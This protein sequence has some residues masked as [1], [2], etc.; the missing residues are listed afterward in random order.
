MISKMFSLVNLFFGMALGSFLNVVAKRTIEGRRWWGRERSACD[1]CGRTLSI[2]DLIPVFSYVFLRGKCRTCKAPIGISCFLVEVIMGLSLWAVALVY[3]PTLSFL[4]SLVLFSC[5]FL[6]SLTD[7]YSGY[8]YDRLV[9][10]FLVTG[11]ALR[12]LGGLQAFISGVLGACLCGLLIWIIMVLSRGGMGTGDVTIA[13]SIGGIMGLWMGCLAL[14]LG[15]MSGGLVAIVLLLAK[16]V[17]RKDHVPM[18]PF[19]A[20]GSFLSL[21]FGREILSFLGIIA[22][23][24][25]MLE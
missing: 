21:M 6:S 2:I 15:F 9:F 7:I 8:V 16:K 11:L 1:A 17:K 5:L 10:P 14:Y 19:F 4:S 24:P 25:W 12:L 23:W 20:I 22:G 13:A 3:G 18:I